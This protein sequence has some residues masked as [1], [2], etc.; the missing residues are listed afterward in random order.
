MNSQHSLFSRYLFARYDN[1]ATYDGK[2]VLTL[3]RTGQENIAHSIVTGHKWLPTN[4]LVNSLNVTFNR[5]LN[6]RPLPEF[7]TATDLGSR[8]SSP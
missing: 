3:S 6:D 1:P 8:V 4:T 5:T 2:N 7:F